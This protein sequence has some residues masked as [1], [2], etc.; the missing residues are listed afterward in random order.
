MLLVSPQQKAAGLSFFTVVW[1]FTSP[2]VGLIFVLLFG[3]RRSLSYLPTHPFAKVLFIS[4]L[5]VTLVIY[6]YI[7]YA[8]YGVQESIEG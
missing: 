7:I 2:V 1:L 8:L 4:F 3:Y 6:G 5:V